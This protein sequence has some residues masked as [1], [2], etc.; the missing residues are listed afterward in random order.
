[1]NVKPT[2]QQYDKFQKQSDRLFFIKP[3]LG[4]GL[5]HSLNQYSVDE[6]ILYDDTE[7]KYFA[8]MALIAKE[9]LERPTDE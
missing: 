7:W 8:E 2:I 3:L 1:M 6:N 9:L 5:Q 4:E